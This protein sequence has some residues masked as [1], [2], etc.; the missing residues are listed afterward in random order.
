MRFS[1]FSH[2]FGYLAH[3]AGVTLALSLAGIALG[4]VIGMAVCVARLSGKPWPERLGAAYVSV[5]RG[6]PLLVLLL[7]IYY[8]L[9]T[10]GLDVPALVAAIGGL[11]LS[12]GAYQ[13]EILRGALNAVPRGQGEAAVALG[14]GAVD[15]WRRILLPQAVRISVPPLI[16][17]FILL[18]KASSL[19][20]VVGIA[21][22]TRVSMNIASMTY[23]PLEAYLAGGFFYLV[24]NLTLAGL[25]SLAERRLARGA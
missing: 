17:E 18:I 10:V 2:S 24:I 5:F 4:F 1:V 15:R 3:A 16:N 19:V 9:A 21:E 13:A 11:S 25:G 23:R 14:Y 7:F 8:F 22:L 20:S 6:V 12:S